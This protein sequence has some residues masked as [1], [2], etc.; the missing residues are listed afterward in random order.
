MSTFY[1]I[2]VPNYPNQVQ[3][4][5]CSNRFLKVLIVYLCDCVCVC[6][7]TCVQ[8]LQRPEEGTRSLEQELE[9]FVSHP[10][11]CRKSTLVYLWELSTLNLWS[12]SPAS[13]SCWFITPILPIISQLLLSPDIN[14]W[15][16]YNYFT[17]YLLPGRDL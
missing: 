9:V 6:V 13:Y 14:L 4:I 15:D 10:K 7:Y 17:L 8:R 5:N 16:H 2:I 1:I 11:W 3:V 12:I